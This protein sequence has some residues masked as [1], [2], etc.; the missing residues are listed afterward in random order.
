[1]FS[2]RT[3]DGCYKNQRKHFLYD[4]KWH[5]QQFQVF[6]KVWSYNFISPS[7]KALRGLSVSILQVGKQG[8][9]RKSKWFEVIWLVGGRLAFHLHRLILDPELSINLWK[10]LSINLSKICE[11]FETWIKTVQ[12]INACLHLLAALP[13][14]NV[15]CAWTQACQTQS[16]GHTA[17]IQ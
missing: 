10:D 11:I 14:T 1:M 9:N 12:V 15:G 8:R 5:H 3:W 13:L 6:Y 2:E 4:T 17:S 7:E 16:R